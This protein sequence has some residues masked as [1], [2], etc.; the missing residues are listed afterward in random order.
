MQVLGHVLS[1]LLKPGLE[2]QRD[3]QVD[4]IGFPELSHAIMLECLASKVLSE[5]GIQV[6]QA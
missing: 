6:N 1:V 4:V 5:H 2:Y 3:A